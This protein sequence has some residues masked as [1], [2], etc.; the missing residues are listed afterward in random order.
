MYSRE[1]RLKR[2]ECLFKYWASVVPTNPDLHKLAM[3]VTALPVTQVSIERE[4]LN[5]SVKRV[6]IF[7][8]VYV[9]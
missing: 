3:K 6:N 8:A 5:S 9:L 7:P 1:A 2:S 4:Q